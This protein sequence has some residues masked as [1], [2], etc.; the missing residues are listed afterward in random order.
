MRFGDV[1]HSLA[2]VSMFSLP[3]QQVLELSHQA[4]YICHRGDPDALTVV[5]VKT[6]TLVV[7]MVP[8]YQVTDDGNIVIPENRFSLLESPFL[9]MAA[10]SGTLGEEEDAIDD[11]T[12]MI[13]D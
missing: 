10:L 9:K 13:V 4:A 1:V 3:D 5:D 2:L 11:A 7:A 12:D 8:D 6:I